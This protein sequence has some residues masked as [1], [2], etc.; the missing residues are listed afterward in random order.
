MTGAPPL[1]ELQSLAK[2][3]G[4]VVVA[5]SVSLRIP[6][7]A[8]F[9][10]VGPNGA[11][12]TSLFHM[13]TGTVKPNAGRVLF[14]GRDITDM[15][16]HA[17]VPLGIM[18]AFQIP[19]PFAHL[20][21]YE[22][23]LMAAYYG[24]GLR[25]AAAESWCVEVLTRVDLAAKGEML[26]GQLRLLDRK[27]LELAKA[28]A[29]RAKLLLLDE[30]AGGLTEREVDELLV[31]I[32]RLKSE[33]TIIW[34]EHIPRVLRAAA[35]KVLVLHFGKL[36]IDGAPDVVMA[37]REFREIYMGIATGAA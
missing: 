20:T 32:Q 10:L 31:L 29:S 14:Q 8:C 6:E 1:L 22:N 28:V 30:I 19:Q 12:K 35:D 13:I 33:H 21:V 37:S 25:R 34:I 36:L 11:G 5:D 2:R 23:V 17:R 27:R 7:G 15:P 18:R 4:S 9:G 24:G 3:Y 26:A 16:A